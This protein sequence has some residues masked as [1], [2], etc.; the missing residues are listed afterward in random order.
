MQPSKFTFNEAFE[1]NFGL[2]NKAEQ[3]RL[4][5]SRI[6]VAGCGGV[7]GV[8]AHTLARLGIGKFRLADPDFFSLANFNR[9]IGATIETIGRQKAQV[10]ARMIES[11]NPEAE[12]DILESGIDSNNVGAFLQGADLVVDGVDFFALPARRILLAKAWER[13]TPV[14]IAAP[15]GFSS[16]LHIFSPGGMSFDE[17]F[18]LWDDQDP[19]EQYVNFLIG[20]APSALH[21]PYTDI[22]TADP[23]TGRGP[24]SIIG[25]Q[26]AA[27][28]AGGEALRILLNRGPS[29]CAP[30]YL[31]IDVYRRLLRS[32]KLRGGNRNLLQRIKKFVIKRYLERH[33]LDIA[34]KALE[35]A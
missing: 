33:G 26:M 24:S 18:D 8:H 30:N 35:P 23:A 29:L 5:S 34:L 22:S 21:A 12:V 28:V 19:Y 1:R 15:L 2:V 9:Q 32:R 27:C 6:A 3:E 4:A 31:Q 13:K 17:Y 10:T 11:I 7:G 16:T 25:S 20:L 14:L